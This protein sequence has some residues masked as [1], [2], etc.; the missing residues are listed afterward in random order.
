MNG[1]HQQVDDEQITTQVRM[2]MACASGRT[3]GPVKGLLVLVS[4]YA[5]LE[6]AISG[7]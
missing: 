4:R 5:R 2:R 6:N 7:G 1:L 3:C